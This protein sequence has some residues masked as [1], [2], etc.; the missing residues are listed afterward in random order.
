[1]NGSVLDPDSELIQSIKIE[2]EVDAEPTETGQYRCSECGKLFEKLEYLRK[3]KK[4]L[5]VHHDKIECDLCGKPFNMTAELTRYRFNNF[6]TVVIVCVSLY[7]K[8]H[9]VK[10]VNTF[11]FEE[12]LLLNVDTFTLININT[13]LMSL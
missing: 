3:H 5:H 2:P 7:R 10:L 9:F 6:F 4:R 11:I 8:K 13:Q 12:V 1:M